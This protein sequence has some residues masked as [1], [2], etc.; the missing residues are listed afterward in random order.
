MLLS[1]YNTRLAYP[2]HF[3]RTKYTNEYNR[4]PSRVHFSFALIITNVIAIHMMKIPIFLLNEGLGLRYPLLLEN[5]VQNTRDLEWP[6]GHSDSY[7]MQEY[8]I[9]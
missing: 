1:K 9:D 8:R 7:H 6:Q 5:Y 3:Y 4:F 2:L